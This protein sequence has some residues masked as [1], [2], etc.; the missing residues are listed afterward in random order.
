METPTYWKMTQYHGVQEPWVNDTELCWPD[1]PDLL[2]L[3]N[4]GGSFKFIAKSCFALHG[5]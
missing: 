3:E 2:Q 5:F 4:A 1:L